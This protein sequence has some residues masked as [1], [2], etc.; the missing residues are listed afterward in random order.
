MPESF[1]W[2]NSQSL[3]LRIVGILTKQ[4][5]GDLT[6]DGSRG[7]TRFELRFPPAEPEV[8]QGVP[9]G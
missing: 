3:G 9:T 6:L 7:G 8:G 2:R 4:I 1:D 5:G